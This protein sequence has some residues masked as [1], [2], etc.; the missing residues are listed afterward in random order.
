MTSY[1]YDERTVS[2]L[3]KD[4]YGFRPREGFWAQWGSSNPDQKQAVWDGLIDELDRACELEKA[5]Y[6][7]ATADFEA[8]VALIQETC[9]CDRNTAIRMFVDSLDVAEQAEM[10]G[11]SYLCFELGLPYGMAGLF[12]EAGAATHNG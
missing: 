6:D 3:H 9:C 8:S 5:E 7:R 11:A 2:D 1:T 12:V 4:A 10:Y